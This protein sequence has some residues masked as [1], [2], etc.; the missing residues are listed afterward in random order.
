MLLCWYAT[1]MFKSLTNANSHNN[2]SRRA[3]VFVKLVDQ[4]EIQIK[5]LVMTFIMG[6]H[7]L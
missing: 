3:Y 4:F 1:S 6:A 2:L 5:C 7:F